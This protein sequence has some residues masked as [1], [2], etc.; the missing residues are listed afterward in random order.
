MAGFIKHFK[1]LCIVS[2]C[3]KKGEKNQSKL[4]FIQIHGT[5]CMNYGSKIATSRNK[6]YFAL[7]IPHSGDKYIHWETKLRSAV[8]RRP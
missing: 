1:N 2:N 7:I 5:E 8:L 3:G 4:K 6:L